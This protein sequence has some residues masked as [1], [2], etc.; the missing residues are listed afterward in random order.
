M[1]T[2]IAVAAAQERST[3]PTAEAQPSRI[4]DLLSFDDLRMLAS[5]A[6]PEGD[7]GA[8]FSALLNTPEEEA[9]KLA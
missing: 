8:R 5:T 4:P 1:R 3:P 9:R 7:L 2:A 6:K